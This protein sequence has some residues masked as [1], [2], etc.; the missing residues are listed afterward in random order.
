MKKLINLISN[1]E[2]NDCVIKWRLTRL[3]N[4]SCPYCVQ[5]QKEVATKE[6]IEEEQKILIKAA[7]DINDLIER[8]KFNKVKLE[9]VGGEVSIFELEKILSSLTSGKLARIQLTSNF[10]KDA[11]YYVNF[12][13]AAQKKGL[14]FTLTA[15]WHQYSQ[16]LETYIS[17]AE[18]VAPLC[19]IF[20][21]E[22]VSTVGNQEG[23]KKFIAS[24]EGH[25]FDYM[26]DADNNR[27]LAN[28]RANHELIIK[29]KKRQKN[30]RYTALFEDIDT[31]ELFTQNYTSRSE[32]I[33]D[34]EIVEL[35]INKF[36][37]TIGFYCTVDTNYVYIEKGMAAG[38]T[39]DNDS[40]TG[41]M[42]IKD[43]NFLPPKKCIHTYCSMCGNMNLYENLPKEY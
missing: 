13:K 16:T 25:N 20:C 40:C 35:Y 11:D 22:S 9:F 19:T 2:P 7:E 1:N 37:K 36:L 12:A 4:L 43:F 29:S 15:S 5:G 41:R 31:K 24:C 17:K 26:I 21:C 33:N 30:P 6:Q 28:I 39:L 32:L 23:I 42:P 27:K 18:K 8:S 34:N 14:E 38:R 3:C 10:Y